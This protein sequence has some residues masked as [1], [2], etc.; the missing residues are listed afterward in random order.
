MRIAQVAPLFESVPP[1]WY[2]GTERVVAYLTDEL[3]RQGHDVTLFASGD[4]R[5]RAELA[6][7]CPQALRLEASCRDELAWHTLMVEQA[8]QR[9]SEFDV[10]HFH[11][12]HVH[13]PIVRR[14]GVPHVTTLHGRLDLPEL[15]PLHCEFRDVPVVSISD[16]QRAPLPQAN[17]VATVPHGLPGHLYR[18]S[19]DGGGY[20]AFLGRVSPEK[21]LDR[22]I[23]IARAVG[24]RLR[25]AAKVDR[26]DRDYFETRIR[27]MLDDPL[28]EFIGEIGESEKGAFL[29]QASALLFPIDWPEPFG[30]VMIEA[31]A[32]GTP[33]LAFRC[34][35]VPEVLDHGVTGFI[36]DDLDE[37]I[38]AAAG[39]DRLDRR[40]CRHAFERRFAAARMARRYV[41]VFEARLAR[42]R[43]DQAVA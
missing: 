5:T 36:V 32:C 40:A 4:S 41:D 17:W 31:L 38:D 10:L 20:F 42:N 15:V 11:I 29:G 33:V 26:V 13:Y 27:P 14:L 43:A 8:V 37:A 30:L 1:R 28:V 6:A 35:S 22:A 7:V 21:R 23:D 19:R 18:F 3:V 2:G 16:A 25:I 39:I 24:K 12:S 34:G 9:A